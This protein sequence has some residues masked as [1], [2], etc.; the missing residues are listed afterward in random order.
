M[1]DDDASMNVCPHQHLE[2]ISN[3]QCQRRKHKPVMQVTF[4]FTSSHLL[5]QG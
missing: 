1:L 2:A 4:G 3:G 5:A